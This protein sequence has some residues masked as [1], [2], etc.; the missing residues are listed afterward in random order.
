MIRRTLFLI[1]MFAFCVTASSDYMDL[2]HISLNGVGMIASFVI[3]ALAYRDEDW[4]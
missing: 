2:W 3:M 4:K 1:A